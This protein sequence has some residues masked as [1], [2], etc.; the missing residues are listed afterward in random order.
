MRISRN[1]RPGA[2]YEASVAAPIFEDVGKVLE[3][4]IAPE[5]VVY[6]NVTEVGGNLAISEGQRSAHTLNVIMSS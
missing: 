1:A 3:N 5:D 4:P 2:L 6:A